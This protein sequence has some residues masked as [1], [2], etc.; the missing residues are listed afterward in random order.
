MSG[1][2]AIR[3]VRA[4]IGEAPL[5]VREAWVGL[6]L[7]ARSHGRWTGFGVLTGPRSCL[8][9][10]WS[11]LRGRGQRVEGFSV[12]AWEAVERLAARN[13]EAAAWWRREAAALVRP[14]SVFV[15]DDAAC[16]AVVR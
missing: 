12:D 16:E 6:T 15:F 4:P 9:Q 5:W 8:G 13:P 3:I 1:A 11:R 2:Q 14:G 7:P 10:L